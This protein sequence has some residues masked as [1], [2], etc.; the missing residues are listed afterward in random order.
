MQLGS[1]KTPDGHKGL[2]KIDRH[3]CKGLG[4]HLL[5]EDAFG[6][7]AK[8]NENIDKDNREQCGYHRYDI[9]QFLL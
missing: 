7:V 3:Q 2:Q 5:F 8:Q 9:N 4:V 6:K 1:A